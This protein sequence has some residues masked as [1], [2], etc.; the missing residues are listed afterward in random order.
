MNMQTHLRG[1]FV[2]AACLLLSLFLSAGLLARAAES[3]GRDFMKLTDAD[4]E[5]KIRQARQKR[6]QRDA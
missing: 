1:R 2:P 3:S 5:R 6:R 4:L